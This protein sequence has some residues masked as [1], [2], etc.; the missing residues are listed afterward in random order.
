MNRTKLIILIIITI[1]LATII[2]FSR[3]LLTGQVIEQ[4][5][6]TY[7]KAICNETEKGNIN[8]ED[9][10]ITCRGNKTINSI[11]TGFAVQHPSDW[12]DPRG[13]DA[14]ENLCK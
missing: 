9:Y 5:I 14:D 8:C 13:E 1:I 11:A 12:K 2:Y 3:G 7:T 6:Y 10:E 4:E